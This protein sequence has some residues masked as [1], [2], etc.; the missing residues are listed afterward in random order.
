[1]GFRFPFLLAGTSVFRGNTGGGGALLQSRMY[2]YGD[3]LFEDNIS[4][5]GG[6]MDLQDYSVVSK[7][8]ARVRHWLNFSVDSTNLR[9]Q[10]SCMLC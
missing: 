8:V 5:N 4:E 7:G 1:M 3:I 9:S 2:A 6:G 10:G